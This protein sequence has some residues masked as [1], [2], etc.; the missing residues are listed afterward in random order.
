MRPRV[1]NGVKVYELT[2][3]RIQ[4]ETEPGKKV[5]A[6]AYNGQVCRARRSR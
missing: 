1:E 6:F 5:E 3:E 2:A 4:W